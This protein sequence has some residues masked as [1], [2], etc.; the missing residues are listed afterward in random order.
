MSE[1]VSERAT[2]NE[3]EYSRSIK[4]NIQV[5][6][7]EVGKGKE[8]GGECLSEKRWEEVVH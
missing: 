4:N 2:V 5:N 3:R 1:C 7:A 6:R 8:G